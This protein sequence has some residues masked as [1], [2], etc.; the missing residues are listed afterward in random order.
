MARTLGKFLRTCRNGRSS[1]A[2]GE[3]NGVVASDSLERS[4]GKGFIC[5]RKFACAGSAEAAY[6]RDYG[7]S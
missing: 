5:S 2:G 4:K 3:I 7:G 1:R 6:D